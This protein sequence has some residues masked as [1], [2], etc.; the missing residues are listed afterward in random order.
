VK[1][2]HKRKPEV[3]FTGESGEKWRNTFPSRRKLDFLLSS[4]T[5]LRDLLIRK[6]EN[7]LLGQDS[8]FLF[9]QEA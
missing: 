8:K 6:N 7:T 1:P 2:K 3:F 5:T 4:G 9:F